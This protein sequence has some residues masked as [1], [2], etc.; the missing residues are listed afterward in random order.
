MN[1]Q[2][3]MFKKRGITLLEVMLGMVIFSSLTVIFLLSLSQ[4]LRRQSETQKANLASF[5]T[6]ETME[7]LYSVSQS[8]Q[9]QED[10]LLQPA[11]NPDPIFMKIENEEV[12]FQT[13]PPDPNADHRTEIRVYKAY[14]NPNAGNNFN[15]TCT[16]LSPTCVE[17]VFFRKVEVKVF[18]S[19]QPTEEV[20][21]ATYY[22]SEVPVIPNFGNVG[23]TPG[24]EPYEA[25]LVDISQP[26]PATNDAQW[27]GPLPGTLDDT[28]LN[29]SL[30]GSSENWIG[31]RFTGINLP[32]NS[33]IINAYIVV[34][35]A[36]NDVLGAATATTDRVLGIASSWP[37]DN[38]FQFEV[39]G[40]LNVANPNFTTQIPVCTFAG[41][42]R[43]CTEVSSLYN[44]A[45]EL[46]DPAWLED[47]WYRPGALTDI[48]Q[49]IIDVSSASGSWTG[50]NQVLTFLYQGKDGVD[51]GAI[52]KVFSIEGGRPPELHIAYTQPTCVSGAECLT[53]KCGTDYDGDGY[54][55]AGPGICLPPESVPGDCYDRN[56]DVHPDQTQFFNVPYGPNNSYDYNCDGNEEAQCL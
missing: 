55:I 35:A 54:Y 52:R 34:N 24:P 43:N 7:N 33:T 56:A 28:S 27:T 16:G 31:I 3:K 39:W 45:D 13:D 15:P 51:A 10:P 21:S 23:P 19:K 37:F 8:S 26:N 18:D 53:G 30:G 1:F 47:V 22:L 9:W 48:V 17:D 38:R 6:Q 49:E 40:D 29:I 11:D 14:R 42:P 46:G 36:A 4:L 41:G 20:S 12:K 5:Y 2:K 50:S 25:T 44:G 32:A